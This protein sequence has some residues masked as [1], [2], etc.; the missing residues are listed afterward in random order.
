MLDW[1]DGN[2]G[3]KEELL[4]GRGYPQAVPLEIGPIRLFPVPRHERKQASLSL[5]VYEILIDTDYSYRRQ[6]GWPGSR[7][8]TF[9][10]KLRDCQSDDT[11]SL[12]H[13]RHVVVNPYGAFANPLVLSINPLSSGANHFSRQSTAPWHANCFRHGG[14]E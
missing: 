11:M 3:A 7:T 1:A 2:A 9:Q 12:S 8:T 14:Q 6:M 10:I 13:H 4:F 5:I